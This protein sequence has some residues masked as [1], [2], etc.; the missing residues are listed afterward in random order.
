MDE[1][2]LSRLSKFAHPASALMVT[3]PFIWVVDTVLRLTVLRLLFTPLAPIALAVTIFFQLEA[4][5]STNA[6]AKAPTSVAAKR[7]RELVVMLL[8]ATA[9]FMLI[10]GYFQAGVFNPVQFPV[11]YSLAL[12]LGGWILTTSLHRR[13]KAREAFLKILIGKA[14]GRGLQ[15]AARNA[16][17]ESGEADEGVRKFRSTAIGLTVVSVVLYIFV[18]ATSPESFSLLTFLLIVQIASTALVTIAANGF[19]WE[20]DALTRGVGTA[21]SVLG[22]RFRSAFMLTVLIVLVA[23]PLAGRQAIVPPAAIDQFMRGVTDQLGRPIEGRMSTESLFRDRRQLEN[24]AP[25]GERQTLGATAERQELTQQIARSVGLALGGVIALGILYF[26]L[27]PLFS[28]D[29]RE[30]MKRFSLRRIVQRIGASVSNA[31]ASVVQGFRELLTSSRR[32]F[33]EAREAVQTIRETVRERQRAATRDRGGAAQK[34]VGKLLR[35]YI[36]LAKWGDKVGYTYQAWMGPYHYARRL[37]SM[38]PAQEEKLREA[39]STFES[40][41]YGPHSATADQIEQFGKAIDEIIKTRP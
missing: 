29:A 39:G 31:W 23:L 2:R 33:R 6:V 10:G 22:R 37:A 32:A 21:G 41:V 17:S 15:E 9:A 19:L 3:I 36:K 25:P 28:K 14:T 30:R 35:S 20:N 26:L 11:I 16:S 5:V 18:R 12:T 7:I 40:L 13:L 34:E 4:V 24:E 27:S 38:V 1:N 8:V